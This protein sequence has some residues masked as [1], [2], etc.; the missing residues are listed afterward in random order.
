LQLP[1]IIEGISTI[2]KNFSIVCMICRTQST[3]CSQQLALDAMPSDTFAAPASTVLGDPLRQDL[4][5]VLGADGVLSGHDLAGRQL[6]DW[7]G[8]PVSPPRALLLP[9]TPQQVAAALRVCSRH[10]QAVSIQGGLTGLAG[11]ANPQSGEVALSLSRL[12]AIEDF[13][14]VGGTVVAQAGV[15]LEQLQAAVA[16][17]GWFFPL[18]LGARGSCQLGGNAATNAGGNR[19]LRYGMMRQSVLGL[20]VALADGTLLTM[21]DRAIKNNAGFDLKHLFIGSEG[22]LGVITRLSLKLEPARAASCTALCAV[23]TFGAS[24]ELLRQARQM[25]PGLTA[26]ELMWD[27][28]FKASTAAIQRPL[29]FE[30]RYPLYVLIETQGHEHA[31]CVAAVEAFLSA[32][33]ESGVVSDAIVAQSMDQAAQLWAYR[34]GVGEL[35]GLHKPS[36]A[37]DVSVAMPDMDRLVTQLRILLNERFPQQSHLFFGHLGDGNLHL[38]SGPYRE[39]VDLEEVERLVYSCV[40]AYGGSISAEHGVGLVKKG[41]L[42]HSRG[43]AEIGLMEQLKR[44]FDPMSILNAGRV[45]DRTHTMDPDPR[46]AA[47]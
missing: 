5:A 29:P 17:R 30:Q 10:G 42:W 12:N 9:R 18:D 34:E 28:F 41:H 16:E 37:F 44:L 21:L 31:E 7:S 38:L 19:V 1:D 26:Y 27:D 36:A 4:L 23:E 47:S 13:D 15:T 6:A 11:G 8:A 45:I 22:T 39:H 2:G 20:E 43:P 25:L 14:P 24:A 3:A 40:G 33:L 32:A 35:L 46:T